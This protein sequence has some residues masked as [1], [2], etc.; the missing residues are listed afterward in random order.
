M[1]LGACDH[2]SPSPPPVTAHEREAEP[3]SRAPQ[4]NAVADSEPPL[5]LPAGQTLGDALPQVPPV[6]RRLASGAQA[7][8]LV[9]QTSCADQ[10]PADCALAKRLE[11]TLPTEKP[12]EPPTIGEVCLCTS[13]VAR[14]EADR[15]SATGKQLVAVAAWP[16]DRKAEA[17]FSEARH[18]PTNLP[19][20]RQNAGHDSAAWGTLVATG[21]PHMPVVAIASA[22]FAD[23]VFGEVVHWQRAA[24]ALYLDAGKLTWRPLGERAFTSLDL[25]YLQALCEGK[26][27]ATQEDRTGANPAACGPAEQAAQAQAQAAADRQTLR[28]KRLKGQGNENADKDADP[29]SIWLREARKQLKAGQWQAAIETALQVDMICGEAIQDAHAIVAEALAQG[30]VTPAKVSPNQP[31]A[32][33]CEPLPDKPAPKRQRVE[34][35][36]PEK[37][38]KGAKNGRTGD[39]TP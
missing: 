7:G 12:G 18:A 14:A 17:T 10:L 9:P 1:A 22:R 8:A 23:G 16:G 19:Q 31:L 21:W 28:Q 11:I 33:L 37:P 26:A 27:D 36:K 4:S 15:A 32:D 5:A 13:A 29:Q 30:H 39:K 35:D 25:N 6:P 3:P 34:A 24:Q 2:K 20:T 38:T